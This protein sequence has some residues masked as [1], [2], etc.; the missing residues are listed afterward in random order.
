VVGEE[1]PETR[2]GQALLDD[3]GRCRRRVRGDGE[4]KSHVAETTR[5]GGLLR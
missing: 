2:V 1:A 3:G 4:R 5:V